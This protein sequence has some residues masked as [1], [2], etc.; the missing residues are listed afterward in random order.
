MTQEEIQGSMAT[1]CPHC[2]SPLTEAQVKTLWASYTASKRIRRGGNPKPVGRRKPS[3][4]APGWS[5]GDP[6]CGKC[7]RCKMTLYQRER[8]ARITK[9]A[10]QA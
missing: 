9:R 6:L 10:S 1:I 7:D 5:P 8:R 3:C 2:G 4:T